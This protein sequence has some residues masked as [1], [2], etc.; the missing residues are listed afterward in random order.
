MLAEIVK[1]TPPW[2]WVLLAGLIAL[3][4]VQLRDREMSRARLLALPLAM[5]LLSLLSTSR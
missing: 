1:G 3:G 4:A 5:V 2:V